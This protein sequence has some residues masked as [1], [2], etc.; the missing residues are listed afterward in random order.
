MAS[1]IEII[2]LADTV[3][4]LCCKIYYSFFKSVQGAPQEVRALLSE[5]EA[6]QEILPSPRASTSV[7]EALLSQSGLAPTVAVVLKACE[8]EFILI[9]TTIRSFHTD[10]KSQ[11]GNILK[12]AS[13]SV[14]W[15]LSLEETIKSTRRL[16]RTKQNLV[17]SILACGV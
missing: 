16:D 3:F 14:S 8:S 5:L 4:G 6:F 17:L 12:K 9:W 11:W 15:V 7:I 10:S 13:K 2:G 1:P